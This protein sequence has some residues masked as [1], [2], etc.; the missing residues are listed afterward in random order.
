MKENRKLGILAIMGVVLISGV[1]Y[2]SKDIIV[3]YLN[4]IVVVALQ[5]IIMAA[6]LTVYNLARKNSFTINKKDILMIVLSGLFG[7]TFFNLFSVMS[8]SYIGGTVSSLLF[9]L[10]AV[11]SL[12]IEFVFYKRRRTSLSIL[13]VALSLVGVYIL[14][15][16]NPADLLGTNLMGYFLSL[17]SIIAWVLFCFFS[18]RVSDA[19]E[20]TVVLNFQALIGVLTTMPFL[21]VYPVSVSQLVNPVVIINMLV[22]GVLNATVAYF[23]CIYAVQHIGLTFSNLLMNFFPVVTV[24]VTFLIYGTMPS[25]NQ[26][27][28]GLIIL[29]SVL[30]LNRDQKNLMQLKAIET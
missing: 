27:I 5:L 26:L 11:F 13:S 16:L 7:T 3:D 1:A 18:D 25:M 28:G 10:A 9:G 23:L 6:L 21:F 30:I 4:P 2:I 29:I 8:I 24:I 15:G 14:M 17:L 12:I 19:Y 20:K 22:L